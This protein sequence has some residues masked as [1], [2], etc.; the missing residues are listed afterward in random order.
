MTERD[1]NR[2]QETIIERDR[3]VPW[4]MGPGGSFDMQKIRPIPDDMLAE[5]AQRYNSHG[6]PWNC[7]SMPLSPSDREYMYLLYYSMQGLVARM[8]EAEQR[9][10]ELEAENAALRADAERYRW[11]TKH[12]FICKCHTDD[13]VILQVHNTDRA[14]PISGPV[15]AAIDAAIDEARAR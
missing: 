1:I 8:R 14:V 11:L 12:A 2:W 7:S 10:A 6:C 3:S 4:V 5:L 9:A 13:G 15:D